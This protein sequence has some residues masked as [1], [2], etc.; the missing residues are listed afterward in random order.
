MENLPCQTWKR[1]RVDLDIPHNPKKKLDLRNLE[2]FLNFRST[3]Y[4]FTVST[5]RNFVLTPHENTPQPIKEA[6]MLELVKLIM[7]R[8]NYVLEAGGALTDIVHFYLHCEGL[9]HDF[10]WVGTGKHIKT[11]GELM[12]SIT[13]RDKVEKLMMMIQSGKDITLN[14][15]TTLTVVTFSPPDEYRERLRRLKTGEERVPKSDNSRTKKAQKSEE[16][17]VL[18]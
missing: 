18:I 14:E 8:M 9:D 3:R 1:P 15:E 4:T 13:V 16:K 6:L 10:K 2:Y 7:E 12:S 17:W 5:E 11:V